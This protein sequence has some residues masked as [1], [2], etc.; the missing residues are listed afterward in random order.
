MITIPL[1]TVFYSYIF[2][3]VKRWFSIHVGST[4]DGNNE[5]NDGIRDDDDVISTIRRT[6]YTKI[7]H[8]KNWI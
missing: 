1:I 8:A 4:R 5:R 7:N 3:Q 6:T 2:I